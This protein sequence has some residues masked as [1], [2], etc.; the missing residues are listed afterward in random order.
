MATIDRLRFDVRMPKGLADQFDSVSL[1]TG[2][3]RGEVFR[4]AIAFYKEAKELEHQK[5]TVMFKDANGDLSR[6]VGL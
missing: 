1:L 5:G 6:V 2:L 4:R 3:P